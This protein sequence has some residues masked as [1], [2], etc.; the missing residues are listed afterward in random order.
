MSKQVY[1]SNLSRSYRAA[2]TG[3][4]LKSK[5]LQELESLNARL[6]FAIGGNN[7]NSLRTLLPQVQTDSARWHVD[8]GKLFLGLARDGDTYLHLAAK[9]NKAQA[10]KML[11]DAGF[12]GDLDVVNRVNL[13]PSQYA[14]P[15]INAMIQEYRAKQAGQ[16]GQGQGVVI[17]AKLT[18]GSQAPA[19]AAK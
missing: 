9:G 13:K 10:F 7:L 16:L 5:A 3:A 2:G 15:A 1:F 17:A 11:L 4:A 19:P 18:S 14:S 8:N 6:V 12:G